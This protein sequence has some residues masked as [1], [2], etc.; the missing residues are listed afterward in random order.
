MK[1]GFK[2][3]F[4][5]MFTG[6]MLFMLTLLV[7]VYSDY[8]ILRDILFWSGFIVCLSGTASFLLLNQNVDFFK[9]MDEI[10]K[11]TK[12]LRAEKQNTLWLNKLLIDQ[13]KKEGKDE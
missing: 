5:L 2:I 9:S 7:Y 10:E 8:I 3:S 6:W 13:I 11:L 4:Y 1:T 12:E